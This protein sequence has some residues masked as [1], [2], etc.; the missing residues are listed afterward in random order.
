VIKENGNRSYHPLSP[1]RGVLINQFLI[2]LR[3]WRRIILLLAEPQTHLAGGKTR[4][5]RAPMPP[6]YGN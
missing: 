1:E 4:G 6:A 2:V 5:Q 3:R